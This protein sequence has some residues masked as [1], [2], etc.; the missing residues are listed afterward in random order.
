[1]LRHVRGGGGALPLGQGRRGLRRRPPLRSGLRLLRLRPKLPRPSAARWLGSAGLCRAVPSSFVFLHPRPP[2]PPLPPPV[3]YCS[4][5]ITPPGC[6]GRLTL[7]PP[8]KDPGD[9]PRG[10]RLSGS[11]GRKSREW[12]RA[13]GTARLHTQ[14]P[15]PRFLPPRRASSCPGSSRRRPPLW[16]AIGVPIRAFP[17]AGSVPTLAPTPAAAPRR[18]TRSTAQPP[19]RRPAPPSRSAAPPLA[20]PGLP[21]AVR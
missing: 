16:M 11:A 19:P 3:N 5:S 4:L 15:A 10:G 17:P 2:P 20:A 13:A 12:T 9:K 7:H 18:C 1:M 14:R 8:A 21:V 6:L